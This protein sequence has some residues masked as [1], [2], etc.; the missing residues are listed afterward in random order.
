MV[1]EKELRVLHLDHWTAETARDTGP[2]MSIWNLR[3]HPQW[4]TKSTPT[5]IRSHLP[6][7]LWG[8]FPIRL[9]HLQSQIW[10]PLK[11]PAQW[12]MS[13]RALAGSM[14]L[15]SRMCAALACR[16][17]STLLEGSL[18]TGLIGKEQLRI[19]SMEL[20]LRWKSSIWHPDKSLDHTEWELSSRTFMCRPIRA[21]GQD[22]YSGE[23]LLYSGCGAQ[24]RSLFLA[25]AHHLFQVWTFL[26][27]HRDYGSSFSLDQHVWNAITASCLIM[28]ALD[29]TSRS[30][31]QILKMALIRPGF[32]TA[33]CPW[34]FGLPP[35]SCLLRAGLALVFTALSCQFPLEASACKSSY[36]AQRDI[37]I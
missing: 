33:L 9:P 20:A 24:N 6:M 4:H 26:F 22:F 30:L 32:T 13:N 16:F 1:L 12:L 34:W 2:V 14:P 28:I 18:E 3:A 31:T 27:P 25:R 10:V 17:Q 35:A 5:P 11:L 29:S 36:L 15:F 7:T 23:V 21:H 37:T 19:L 8:P